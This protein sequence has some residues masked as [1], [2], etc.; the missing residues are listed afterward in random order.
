MLSDRRLNRNWIG[1]YN[2][3]CESFVWCV[4]VCLLHGVDNR[5]RGLWI[6]LMRDCLRT[7]THFVVVSFR[8]V[9]KAKQYNTQ[10]GVVGCARDRTLFLFFF[11]SESHVKRRRCCCC[12]ACAL[13]RYKNS[14][15]QLVIVM[16]YP[17]AQAKALGGK[18][19]KLVLIAYILFHNGW[20]DIEQL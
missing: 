4:C 3:S 13:S 15:S 1:Y 8:F 19:M 14:Y 5:P 7:Q 16:Q 10:N 17:N 18:F 6:E 11:Q 20:M 12:S 9:S 2:I